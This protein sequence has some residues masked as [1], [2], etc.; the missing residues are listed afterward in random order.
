MFS[1]A[2]NPIMPLG[3]DNYLS[4]LEF[5]KG[6]SK[7]TQPVCL[8]GDFLFHHLVEMICLLSP[9]DLLLSSSA[10]H[11]CS[12]K[13]ARSG[14]RQGGRGGRFGEEWG[15]GGLR[16]PRLACSGAL[17][18]KDV[19]YSL[20]SNSRQARINQQV[21]SEASIHHYLYYR[22]GNRG[23]HFSSS[24]LYGCSHSGGTEAGWVK[25][26]EEIVHVKTKGFHLCASPDCRNE[27]NPQRVGWPVKC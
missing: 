11:Y 23:D 6:V 2:V 22:H 4:T 21:W 13:A 5:L 20:S 9:V 15:W 1:L 26:L 24:R 19:W 7:S 17:P 8:S 16:L 14:E 25:S 18:R 27:R 10:A 3:R 12:R